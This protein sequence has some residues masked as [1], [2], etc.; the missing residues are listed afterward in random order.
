MPRRYWTQNLKYRKKHSSRLHH[1]VWNGFSILG[2]PS[3]FKEVHSNRCWIEF[4]YIKKKIKIN[5]LYFESHLQIVLNSIRNFLLSIIMVMYLLSMSDHFRWWFNQTTWYFIITKLSK[6]ESES[7]TTDPCKSYFVIKI[8]V[9]QLS[10][11][12]IIL[13]KQIRAL[14]SM[15]QYH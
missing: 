5:F 1:I 6:L 12:H 13:A 10:H 14:H 11:R 3:T 15:S 8:Q 7:N 9:C 4:H 2:E